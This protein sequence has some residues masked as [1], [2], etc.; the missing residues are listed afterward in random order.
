LSA[1]KTH[2]R[3][4]KYHFFIHII[5]VFIRKSIP[6]SLFSFKTPCLFKKINPIEQM[7]ASWFYVRAKVLR[8]IKTAIKKANAAAGK[9]VRW[10]FK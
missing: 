3:C 2:P 1:A 5:H 4:K 7:N 6:N 10:L 8:N 9:T